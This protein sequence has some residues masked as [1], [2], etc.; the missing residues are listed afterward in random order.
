MNYLKIYISLI[1]SAELRGSP[2]GY[3]ESHHIFPVSIYG[4]NKRTVKLT[5]KEH[6]IA[7]ALLER[8]F[9]KRYGE[10]NRKSKKMIHAFFMMNNV[11]GVNQKRH[12]NSNLYSSNRVRFSES[13]TGE[14]SRFYGIKRTFSAEHLANLKASRKRGKDNL[15][16]GIPRKEEIKDKIREAKKNISEE[17]KQK[18]SNSRKGMKFSEE[19]KQKLS[20]SHIGKK[21]GNFGK[22]ASEEAKRNMSIAQKNKP[23]FTQ[24]H[25][26]NLS[27]AGKKAW[28][29]RKKVNEISDVAA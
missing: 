22:T 24:N 16:F 18:I 15:Q 13:I 9:I 12:S 29:L 4:K 28:E 27:I 25:K 17:T 14:N 2:T 7:H 1:R 8:I 3:V 10:N 26:N 20:L 23:E 5:A 11:S 21:P 19:H 6:Y